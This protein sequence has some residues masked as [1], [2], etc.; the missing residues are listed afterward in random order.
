MKDGRD[1][2]SRDARELATRGE[3]RQL[4]VQLGSNEVGWERG[5]GRDEWDTGDAGDALG[6]LPDRCAGGD[7]RGRLLAADEAT[8]HER[9]RAFGASEFADASEL[10]GVGDGPEEAGLLPDEGENTG[11][12]SWW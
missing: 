5:R 1:R 12:L 9:L 4:G 6:L 8:E 2:E 7:D 3:E 10:P 11:F